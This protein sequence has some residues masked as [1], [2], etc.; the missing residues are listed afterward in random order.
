MT[1]A[2]LAYAALLAASV[3]TGAMGYAV[4][5][6][7]DVPDAPA[8]TSAP[9]PAAPPVIEPPAVIA[10]PPERQDAVG[11]EMSG[12]ASS[13]AMPAEPDA[14][15]AKPA[16]A[17]EKQASQADVPKVDVP[18][19]DVAAEVRP[20]IAP[21]QATRAPAAPLQ[22]ESAAESTAIPQTKSAEASPSAPAKPQ[23]TATV[24]PAV[25]PNQS[26][27]APV[28]PVIAP[29][30]AIAPPPTLTAA[31]PPALAPR[32]A[33][34]ARIHEP[35]KLAALP[36][37]HETPRALAVN[38]VPQIRIVR[39]G[40]GFAKAAPSHAAVQQLAALPPPRIIAVPR[41]EATGI[42]VLRGGPRLR[43]APAG[44]LPPVTPP[45]VTVVRGARPK[46]PGL[47]GLAHPGPLVLRIQN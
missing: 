36:P 4:I 40:P 26:A 1:R 34:P 17:P 14:E 7:F 33:P 30:P 8:A 22:A 42:T 39:G 38:D 45:A 44:I 20:G 46:A 9:R 37:S 16:A 11:R 21:V 6:A 47:A 15:P 43:S 3:S 41:N 19:A 13:R 18:K 29:A 28:A 2:G 12:L 35:Q 23:Q 5:W 31:P 25:E 24:A 27:P 32:I 10:T